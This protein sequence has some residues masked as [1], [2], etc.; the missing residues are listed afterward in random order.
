MR[1][2]FRAACGLVLTVSVSAAEPERLWRAAK[3]GDVDAVRQVLDE[4][5][6]ADAKTKYGAT[7]LAFAAERGHLEVV[8]L[9]IER[10]ADVN[11][12]DEF[13]GFTPRTW[14][15][16][17]GHQ[18]VVK[19]L[20]EHGGKLNMGLRNRPKKTDETATADSPEAADDSVEVGRVF[21]TLE[22]R[23][24]VEDDAAVSSRHWPQ[25]RGQGA[26][27]LADGQQPPTVWH[28]AADAEENLAWRTRIPG[29][30]N[31]SP[32]IWGDGLFVTT[33]ISGA[34]NEDLKI[35]FYGSVDSVEDD[36]RHEYYLYCLNKHNGEMIWRQRPC[37][38]VPLVKRHLKSTHADPSVATDGR[39]VVAFFG[40]AGLYCYDMDGGLIWHKDLGPIDSGWFYDP[41]YQWEFGSSPIIHGDL[42]I[43]QCDVQTDS[44]VAAFDV[45]TGREV[46]RTARDE[47]PGWATPTVHE[48]PSGPLLF[49]NGTREMRCYFVDTGQLAW[50]FRDNSEITVPT[51]FVA[52][53]MA[54]LAAGYSPIQPIRAIQLEARGDLTLEAGVSQSEFVRW[55]TRKG[56]PYL[57]TPIAYR[58]H[59]Y[60]C[61]N[62]GILTCYDAQSGAQIYRERLDTPGQRSFVGSPVAADDYLY[63]PAEDGQVLVVRAGPEFHQV[64]SNDCGEPL[65][66]TPAISEGMIFLR[67]QRHV[68][69]FAQDQP[70]P[71]GDGSESAL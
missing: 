42:V 59:L 8:Q 1:W 57:P 37:A 62:Q 17:G 63:F 34:E 52:Y 65:L 27:G 29:L 18:Q 24:L 6:A 31:S 43:V 28:G 5:V 25:F 38:Q 14:A 26:R 51:P 10:G 39:H 12:Q 45:E 15:Q 13:Y 53:G 21:P 48:T 19:L 60:V 7:A 66:S 4:G 41:D 67:G 11:N 16:F 69:A 71:E 9:L 2:L 47:I 46:W 36:S 30:G 23:Q 22:P 33:A 64:G 32:V 61:S 40:A 54:F 35:G 3:V 50:S 70:P 44:F 56:G 20:D 58:G 49:T 55:S 68:M